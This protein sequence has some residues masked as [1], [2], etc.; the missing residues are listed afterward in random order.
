MKMR[1]GEIPIA[2]KL[3]YLLGAPSP[4]PTFSSTMKIVTTAALTL[5]QI[6]RRPALITAF[7]NNPLSK[8]SYHS[9]TLKM[10]DSTVT[11]PDVTSFMTSQRPPETKD[12]IMQQT[13]FRVKDPVKSLEFYCNVL[14]FKLIHYSEVSFEER[15]RFILCSV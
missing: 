4:S 3:L 8:A 6:H 15:E 12:Y 9:S 10:S 14:G 5:L 2:P 11:Q 13:M 7:T 1:G